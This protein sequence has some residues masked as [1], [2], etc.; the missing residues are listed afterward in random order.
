MQHAQQVMK[1]VMKTGAKAPKVPGAAAAAAQARKAS[2]L[3]S[4][5]SASSAS[6]KSAKS[7]GTGANVKHVEGPGVKTDAVGANTLSESGIAANYATPAGTDPKNAPWAKPQTISFAD[8]P[9]FRPNL[10]PSQMFRLGAFMDAGGYWRPIFSGVRGGLLQHEHKEFSNN[11]LHWWDGIPEKLMVGSKYA[12]LNGG[13]L[14]GT[15]SSLRQPPFKPEKKLNRFGAKCGADLSEWERKDWIKEQDPY[16]WVQWYCR[17]YN[18]RRTSDD[19]RQVQ[20]WLNLAGPKGRFRSRLINQ[21]VGGM[22]SHDDETVSP[23]IR[24]VLH[25]WGLAI[26]S[27]MVQAVVNKV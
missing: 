20:R 3:S 10:T 22:R 1:S 9:D 8:Y 11:G 26:T 23:V 12:D 4:A 27:E 6:A 25:H 21:I 19:A 5:S 15:Y 16:G 7:S 14:Q 18:G 13:P 24:Q 17:F 2:T